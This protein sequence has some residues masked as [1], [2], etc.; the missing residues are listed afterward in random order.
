MLTRERVPTPPE[1]AAAIEETART[2][3]QGTPRGLLG[4]LA[5]I[6]FVLLVVFG[7]IGLLDLIF[8]IVDGA[9]WT[10][11]I[12]GSAILVAPMAFA[13]LRS[14]R[15]AGPARAA[16]AAALRAEAATGEA[17]RH[18]LDRDARHWFVAHEHGVIMVCPATEDSTLYLDLSS[19]SDDVRHEEWYRSGRLHHA[20]WTWFTTPA[21]AMQA[22][23]AADGPALPPNDFDAA[24]G[25]YDPETGGDLFEFLGSPADGDV[26][27]RPFAE[28]DAFLRARLPV[29]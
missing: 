3:A 20:R 9:S 28:V 11:L 21:G 22:G 15:R 8:G 2:L 19:V 16:M 7:V 24:A 14:E 17:I 5:G 27:D 29:R 6:G 10:V 18:Q 23:F 1:I 13:H 4:G 25:R 12:I 26:I